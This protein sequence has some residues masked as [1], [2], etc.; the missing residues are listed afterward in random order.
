HSQPHDVDLSTLLADL[1]GDIANHAVDTMTVSSSSLLLDRPG[2]KSEQASISTTFQ[3]SDLKRDYGIDYGNANVLRVKY[4]TSSPLAFW[5][6]LL[7]S[8]LPVALIV[9]VLIFMMRQAQGSNNQALTF[10]K[11]RARM[12]ASNKP[13]VTFAD[14]AGVEEAKQELQEVVEFLKF[15]DKFA[16]LGARVPKGVLLVGPPGTGKTLVARAVAGEAG[17]PFFSISGSEFVEMVV[18]VGARRVRD[19][20]TQ[21]EAMA[22]CIVFIDELDALGKARG[23]T[24]LM[25]GHDER[26]QTLNQLLVEMDGFDS[27][28]GVCILSATNRL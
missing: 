6:S 17:V 15:P 10:G 22:P 3:V 1:R 4:A 2:G 25:G 7:A 27:R 8:L 9:G 5:G 26:E 18:G 19:L 28:K 12:F 24:P 20:F 16:A 13:V 23:A 14:V 21:A 11:A